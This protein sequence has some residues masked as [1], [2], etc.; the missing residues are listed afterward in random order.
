GAKIECS[1]LFAVVDGNYLFQ[2]AAGNNRSLPA[3]EVDAAETAAA[4]RALSERPTSSVKSQLE[5]ALTPETAY[6]EALQ[7]QQWV[8]S[9]R[10]DDL[11]KALAAKQNAFEQDPRLEAALL[12]TFALF[13]S[14]RPGL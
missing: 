13:A 3:S 8:E 2:D 5:R 4:N 1:G 10:F 6:T 12:D 11:T 9:R 14:L 7:F